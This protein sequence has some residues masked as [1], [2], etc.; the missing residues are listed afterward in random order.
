M[1]TY[2]DLAPEEIAAL[3]VQ[4]PPAV[5]ALLHALRDHVAEQA[6]TL[7][8]QAQTIATLTARVHQLEDQLH[9]TSHNSHQPPASDGF[10]KQPRSLRTRSGKPSGGQPGHPGHTLTLT[11]DPDHVVRHRPRHCAA[12]GT[13]LTDQP[14]AACQRR[15]V[16]DLPPLTLQTIEHQ[17]ESVGCPA[18]GHVTAAVGPAAASAP[19]QYG[20]HLQALVVLLRAYQLLPSARTQELLSDLL[21]SAPSA[22]PLDTMLTTAATTLEPVVAQIGAGVAAAAVA[23]F[24]ES[25]CYVEDK[26]YWLHVAATARLTYYRVHPQRGQAGSA[27]AG[28]LPAF[29]GI[30]VHDSYA[31]YWTYGCGHALCNAHILRELAGVAERGGQAWATQVAD[32]LREMLAATEHARAAPA[33]VVPAGAVGEYEQR[34]RALVT[35]GLAANPVRERG[36][37]QARGR[38]KQSAATNLLLRLRDHEAEVV[39]FLHDGRVPFDNN[40][41]ERDIRMVKMQQKIAGRFRTTAGAETFCCIRSYISTLRKQGLHIF[42]ALQQVFQGAPLMPALAG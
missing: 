39:R 27:A 6:Q 24:D 18:C 2:L 14:A 37:E 22:G 12:C 5:V 19:I 7:A 23:H 3:T 33:T 29:T 26:R 15:Q 25:G 34:Y 30:A 28:V 20:P 32:L 11:D 1:A 38:V 21:G 13:A 42:T 31:P 36:P 10:N 9:R 40:Q 16:V 8:A 17:L 35:T 41:A 4:A